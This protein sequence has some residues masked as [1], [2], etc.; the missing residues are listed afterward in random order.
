LLGAHAANH[1]AVREALARC[2]HMTEII[3]GMMAFS[4]GQNV[5]LKNP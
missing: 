2:D 3:K 4:L 5:F 1:M